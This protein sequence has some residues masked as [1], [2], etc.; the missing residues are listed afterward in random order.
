[1]LQIESFVE[2][3]QLVPSHHL[4]HKLTKHQV[5][6]FLQLKNLQI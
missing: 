4:L 5:P 6:F 3:R 1:M 2:I